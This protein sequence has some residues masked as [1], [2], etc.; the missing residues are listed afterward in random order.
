MG[1]SAICTVRIS[2]RPSLVTWTCPCE[3][4]HWGLCWVPPLSEIG[5]LGAC[6]LDEHSEQDRGHITESTG[7]YAQFDGISRIR[8][9]DEEEGCRGG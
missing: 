1:T 6:F 3:Q 7:I 9:Q 5:R 2:S 8:D 4:E